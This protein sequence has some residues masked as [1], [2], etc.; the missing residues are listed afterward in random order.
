MSPGS[1]R[2]EPDINLNPTYPSYRSMPVT[3]IQRGLSQ[4]G[5]TAMWPEAEIPLHPSVAVWAASGPEY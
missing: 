5:W 2:P 4:D 1:S 3:R